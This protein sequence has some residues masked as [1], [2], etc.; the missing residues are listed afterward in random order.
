MI[1]T[2]LTGL[3]KLMGGGFPKG[4]AV[5]LSGGPGAGKT[6]FGLNFLVDG[7]EKG[8]KCYYLSISESL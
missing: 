3:D 4:T 6:L 2:G 8:E 1:T 7:A 5:L